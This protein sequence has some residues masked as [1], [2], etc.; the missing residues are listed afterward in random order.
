MGRVSQLTHLDVSSRSPSSLTAVP[1]DGVEHM[2]ETRLESGIHVLSEYMPS[3]R[4]AAVGV[5]VRQG[6]A[7]EIDSDTGVS[8]LL[9]H[10]VFKG[11]E[12]RSASE[13][14]LSLESLGGLLDAYTTREHTS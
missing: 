7:H 11:T 1:S 5:W 13:I 14:A 9:E 12:K 6:S 3:V 4:S 8:H 10:M 2:S